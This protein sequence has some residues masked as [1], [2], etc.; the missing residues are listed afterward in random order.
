MTPDEQ[1]PT[2]EAETP[3]ETAEPNG[4][5]EAPLNRAE[6]RAKGKKGG[7]GA[8]NPS[9][10]NNRVGGF[11]ARTAFGAN[12]TRFPRTGHK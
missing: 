5:V 1:E 4:E 8:G 11:T 9:G 2:P 6:R 3:G 7:T 12:K 10:L